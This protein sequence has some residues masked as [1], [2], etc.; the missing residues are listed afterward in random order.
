MA[1][2]NARLFMGVYPTG[3]V[4][5]DKSREKDGDY[6]RC[7]FLS[8]STLELQWEED[9]PGDL[10]AEIERDAE[11]IQSMRGQPYPIDASGNTV[12]LGGRPHARE[13]SRRHAPRTQEAPP[14]A[15]M[16]ART[17]VD[18]TAWYFEGGTYDQVIYT[19]GPY[20]SRSAAWKAE[21]DFRHRYP[22]LEWGDVFQGMDMGHPPMP[23][24]PRK[25]KAP[26]RK[27]TNRRIR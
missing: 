20:P 10:R 13:A 17:S 19:S 23:E 9:C 21:A 12:I 8:F 15:E 7:A 22:D 4:Y 16:H 2:T 25:K 18:P 5:A 1:R 24:P 11:R 6:A 14:A 3:I 26:A 27:K